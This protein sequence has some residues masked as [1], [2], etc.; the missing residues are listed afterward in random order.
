M[1]RFLAIAIMGAALLSLG[2]IHAQ[3]SINWYT[4]GGGGGSSSGGSGSNTF[5]L[6]GTIGQPATATMSGGSFAITGGFWSFISMVQTPGAPLLSVL[7]AGPQATISW[8]APATGFV[9]QQSTNLLS[10]WA[11]SSATLATNAGI[12]S[13]TVPASSGHLFF[14]LYNP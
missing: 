8:P 4:I 11:A 3:Y 10:G 7:R 5:T 2:V 14:R 9:L 6:S 13:A 1:K 12:I